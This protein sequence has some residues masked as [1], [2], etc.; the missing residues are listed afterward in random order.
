[1]TSVFCPTGDTVNLSVSSGGGSSRVALP[2]LDGV[3]GA[4]RIVKSASDPE[5]YVKF[6]DSG[7]SASSDNMRIS[8]GIQILRVPPG[9]T[10]IAGWG[11]SGTVSITAGQ[12]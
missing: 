2:A 6:G 9:A 4:I 12:I 1:M 7:V 11:G 3:C 8:S 5:I 10:H